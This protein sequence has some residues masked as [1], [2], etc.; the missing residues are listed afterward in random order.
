MNGEGGGV[1]VGQ[2]CVAVAAL[3]NMVRAIVEYLREGRGT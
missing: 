3:A 1:V 2:V